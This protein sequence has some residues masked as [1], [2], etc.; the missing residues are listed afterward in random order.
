MVIW[1]PL[2]AVIVRS[3]SMIDP[4]GI[5]VCG[6]PLRVSVSIPM[7]W[8]QAAVTGRWI[9]MV[10]PTLKVDASLTWNEMAPDG[11]YASVMLTVGPVVAQVPEPPKEKSKCGEP[12][13]LRVVPLEADPL[14]R[15]TT[16]LAFRLIVPATA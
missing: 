14:P 5:Q 8:I 13:M 16:P 7:K 12:V 2:I 6:A 1:F 4:T 11:T 10:S 15:S 3:V 9:R